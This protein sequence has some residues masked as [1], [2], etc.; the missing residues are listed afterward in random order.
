MIVKS[1]FMFATNSIDAKKAER[2]EKL[3]ILIISL[4]TL[5]KIAGI[6]K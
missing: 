6:E 5:L 1:N 4:S 3:S 2:F